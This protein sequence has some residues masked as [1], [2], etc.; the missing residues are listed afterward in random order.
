MDTWMCESDK[1]R[2]V[3]N[4]AQLIAEVIEDDSNISLPE[5][6]P[7]WGSWSESGHIPDLWSLVTSRT[8]A[9]Q[10][11][12]HRSR[13]SD[14]PWLFLSSGNSNKPVLFWSQ[15]NLNW[16]LCFVL[17]AAVR[18]GSD[19]TFLIKLCLGISRGHVTERILDSR[20]MVPSE[21]IGPQQYLLFENFCFLTLNFGKGLGIW[22]KVSP[23]LILMLRF[24]DSIL[25]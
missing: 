17:N 20:D 15:L 24:L 10:L 22:Q 9:S 1:L 8:R 11:T 12:K 19:D 21:F 25:L 7:G 4:P 14:Q 6:M 2:H 18:G 3:G 16:T 23:M 13:N 5:K